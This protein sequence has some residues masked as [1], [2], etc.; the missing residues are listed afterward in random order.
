ML[1]IT[2]ISLTGVSYAG[3]LA[4]TLPFVVPGLAVTVFLALREKDEA[5]DREPAA[6]LLYP[7]G[8]SAVALVGMLFP[9]L[10]LTAEITV[11]VAVVVGFKAILATALLRRAS[12]ARRLA[13]E[14]RESLVGS[15]AEFALFGS[16]GVL[17]LSPTQLQALEPLGS[18]LSSLS[19]PLVAPAL[20]LIMAVGWVAGIHMIPLILLVNAAFTLN[21][22][23]VPA[24]WA[25]AILLGAQSA[26]LLTPSS[27]VTTMLSRLAGLHSLE[28]GLWRN[29]RFRLVIALA[30]LLY[31]GVLTLLLLR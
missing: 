3:L 9:K 22:G 10:P 2:A 24:L 28:V 30:G 1:T 18:V 25:V 21:A 31:L 23:P 4:A 6:A 5:V 13:R 20:A 8:I 11:T 17:V 7:L 14:T 19:P 26:I 27:N 12:P 29:W 16:A 15:H